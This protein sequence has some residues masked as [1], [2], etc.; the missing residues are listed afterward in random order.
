MK[1]KKLVFILVGILLILI[2]SLIFVILN[3]TK[4]SDIDDNKQNLE[5]NANVEENNDKI[6]EEVYYTVNFDS[7]GGSNTDS[8]VVLKEE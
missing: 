7:D 8:V 5:Q 2:L 6:V 1:N 3:Y 4:N